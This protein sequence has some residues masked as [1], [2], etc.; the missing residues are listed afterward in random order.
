[1][2]IQVY[3]LCV[4]LEKSFNKRERNHGD[5]SSWFVQWSHVSRLSTDCCCLSMLLLSSSFLCSSSRVRSSRILLF[6]KNSALYL[7]L[8]PLEL[9]VFAVAKQRDNRQVR[10]A[11]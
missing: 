9:F 1:M 10:A 8:K 4:F 5:F 2:F 7:S 6:I 11:S 3:S